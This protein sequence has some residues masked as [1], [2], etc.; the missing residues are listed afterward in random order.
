MANHAP[1]TQL[2]GSIQTYKLLDD[3]FI[4]A[5]G[6]FVVI[7]LAVMV[8]WMKEQRGSRRSRRL[9][10]STNGLTDYGTANFMFKGKHQRRR[11]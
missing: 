2:N 9:T 5:K 1:W 3:G 4:I 6:T 10:R 8:V 11:S 7:V